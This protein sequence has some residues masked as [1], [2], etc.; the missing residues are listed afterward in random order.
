[1]TLEILAFRS[2]FRNTSA[3]RATVDGAP[4]LTYYSSKW[5]WVFALLFH[6]SM[7]VILARHLRFAFDP[8][9]TWIAVV[10]FVDGVFQVGA[11]RFYLTDAFIL[12]ALGF[13]LLRRLWNEKLRYI[14]LPADYFALFLLL[15]IVCSG[16]W[17]RYL[18]KAD[19]AG[20]K[21]F[22]MGLASLRPVMPDRG[23]AP[24][25]LVHITFVS[26]LLMYFPF[27]KLMHMGGVFLSPTRNM[28]IDTRRE[29]HVN[30]WNPPKKYHTYAAYEDDFRTAMAEA[31][32]PLEK[33]PEPRG[34]EDG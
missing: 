8:V 7:L 15:G 13:L 34:G 31:G 26:T 4:R 12:A 20:I 33:Q 27:S 5:L 30:P 3:V 9:P 1:M 10:E 22:V 32:L 17:M 29:R 14:S 16:I 23:L 21:Q 28:K 19:I 2:L 18:G 24:V 11:P 25:F 6:Y